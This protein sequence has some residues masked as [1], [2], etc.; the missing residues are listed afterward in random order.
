[1]TS[2]TVTQGYW[3]L[4]TS[5][6]R[7]LVEIRASWRVIQGMFLIRLDPDPIKASIEM[8]SCLL[9]EAAPGDPNEGLYLDEAWWHLEWVLKRVNAEAHPEPLVLAALGELLSVYQQLRFSMQTAVASAE[10]AR[11]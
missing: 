11:P 1:M 9:V 6:N 4:N 7:I 2:L 8:V 3:T 10:L 5:S